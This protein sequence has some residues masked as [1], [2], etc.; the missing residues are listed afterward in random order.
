MR[1]IGLNCWLGHEYE[2]LHDF[3]LAQKG[4]TDFFCFQEFPSY[5]QRSKNMPFPPVKLLN[6]FKKLLA[7][8]FGCFYTSQTFRMEHS[9]KQAYVMND[10]LS[11]FYR[12]KFHPIHKVGTKV[13]DYE[14]S[15][16]GYIANGEVHFQTVDFEIDGKLLRLLNIHGIS[17]P[18]NKLD[19]EL[20][21]LQSRAIVESSWLFSGE[22]IVTGDFNLLPGTE[23][24]LLLE[25]RFRNLI[26][27]YEIKNTRSVLTGFRGKVG[28][29]PF[30]DYT[31]VTEGI[32]VRGFE[33]PD[34]PIS[35]HLPLILDF[36]L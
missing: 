19:S 17:F 3:V 10:G 18:T 1:L 5:R 36:E 8:E 15:N 33:V 14:D 6:K 16:E 24:I 21:L 20:R 31:F 11:I 23:S 13:F 27:A 22:T 28:E 34:I 25:E 4:R 2:A 30:A 12:K 9:A 26:T 7:P 29:Q 35:D 32:Q